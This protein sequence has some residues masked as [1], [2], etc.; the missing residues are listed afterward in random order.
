VR[1]PSSKKISTSRIDHTVQL[2]THS[3]GAEDVLQA[4]A[5]MSE[6]APPQEVDH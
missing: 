5:A 6:P 4:E 3:Q 2:Y 1:Q